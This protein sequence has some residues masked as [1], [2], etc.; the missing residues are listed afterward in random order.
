MK[1]VFVLAM[2]A[3]ALTLSSCG[4]STKK[5]AAG[6]D[7]TAVAAGDSA[8]AEAIAPADAVSPEVAQLSDLLETKDASKIQAS[9]TTIKDKIAEL[10]KT[11]PGAAKT[12]VNQLQNWLKTN[13]NAVK[14][15]TGNDAAASTV[16][17][18]LTS[19]SSDKLVEGYSK[20]KDAVESVT[21][22][23]EVENAKST[24]SKAAE[25][26]D[27]VKDK[28]SVDKTVEEVKTKAKDK[29]KEETKK[30]VSNA[31]NQAINSLLK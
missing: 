2:A 20:A 29:A 12:Y 30:A 13:A 3:A 15:A 4:D 22:S 8:N 26:Y 9:L 23:T 27:K 21:K 31:A 24:A 16:I 14:E 19:T 18:A 17:D 11:D 28:E 7:T 6:N 25:V 5:D 1:K 10:S